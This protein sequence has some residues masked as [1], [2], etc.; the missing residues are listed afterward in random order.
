MTL[1]DSHLIVS[2]LVLRC[3][4][5]FRKKKTRRSRIL[6]R[7]PF[8]RRE[9]YSKKNKIPAWNTIWFALRYDSLLKNYTSQETFI[10]FRLRG[11]HS[12]ICYSHQDLH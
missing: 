7:F 2:W 10:H 9:F 6:T 11:F 12:N 5:I 3:R 4:T 1:L 8:A